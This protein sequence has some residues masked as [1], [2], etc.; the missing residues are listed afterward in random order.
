MGE[1]SSG[2]KL[3]A[4]FGP[5]LPIFTP[6]HAFCSATITETVSNKNAI[7]KEF[8]SIQ[9]L[10]Q[11]WNHVNRLATK[12]ADLSKPIQTTF[13]A[14]VATIQGANFLFKVKFDKMFI[15]VLKIVRAKDTAVK[16]RTLEQF[17]P[18]RTVKKI[19]SFSKTLVLLTPIMTAIDVY[20]LCKECQDQD[21][22]PHVKDILA[23]LNLVV[24]DVNT[25]ENILQLLGRKT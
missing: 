2:V 4:D 7:E 22:Q 23:Q 17:A 18:K 21:S 3:M 20:Q 8:K 19:G 1:N 24:N 9:A 5:H 10:N 13:D 15:E 16:W 6:M 14:I 11:V 12:I 25:F